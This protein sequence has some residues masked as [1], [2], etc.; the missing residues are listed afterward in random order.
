MT[1]SE[2][3]RLLRHLNDSRRRYQANL[4][5][6]NNGSAYYDRHAIQEA[7]DDLESIIPRVEQMKVDN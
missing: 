1:N 3:T 6:I 5:E 2:K 7:L 4:A